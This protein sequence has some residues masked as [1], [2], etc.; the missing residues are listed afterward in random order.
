VVPPVKKTSWDVESI[1]FKDP[2]IFGNPRPH[3]I[4]ADGAVA[5]ADSTHLRNGGIARKN[6]DSKKLNKR[7]LLRVVIDVFPFDLSWPLG[8]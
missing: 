3:W 2:S 4:T 1:F 8:D 6:R 7:S 5:D